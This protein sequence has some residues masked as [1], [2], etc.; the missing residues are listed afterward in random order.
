MTF[1]EVARI[2]D[3]LPP[4]AFRHRGWWSN[5]PKTTAP[6]NAWLAA[7]VESRRSISKASW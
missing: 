2:V 4:S 6:R 5:N 7:A 3:G 1:A